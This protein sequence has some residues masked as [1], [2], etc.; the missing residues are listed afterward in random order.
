MQKTKNDW[1]KEQITAI[2]DYT[3]G[4]S[5][6][7]GNGRWIATGSNIPN[8][9]TIAYSDNGINWI[10]LGIPIFIY[11]CYGVAYGNGRWVAVGRGSN[12]TIAYSDN[13]GIT[14][15]ATGTNIYSNNSSSFGV[16]YGNGRWISVGNS[17]TTNT[18]AYS[19]DGIT[20]SGAGNN[21]FAIGQRVSYGN[22]LWTAVGTGTN[23]L[24]YSNDGINWIG[25]GTS[26]FSTG[27]IIITGAE[28]LKEIVFAYHIINQYLYNFKDLALALNSEDSF[29]RFD[30]LLLNL[31]NKFIWISFSRFFL[32]KYSS[33]N[34]I[35]FRNSSLKTKLCL[36]YWSHSCS[37][38]FL[39]I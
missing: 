7:Y 21:I 25:I 24:A 37:S 20:W 19:D 5:V 28:T 23:S 36:W 3:V 31:G 38:A 1:S 29:S 27:K 4:Q 8:S 32:L 11:G 14:W 9:N 10:G 17:S 12:Y 16:A 6:A 34:L 18:I 35:F 22:G 33:V 26:I 39:R 13:N 30:L 2:N 15:T